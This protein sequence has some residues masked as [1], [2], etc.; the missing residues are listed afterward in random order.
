MPEESP[1]HRRGCSRNGRTMDGQILLRRCD[2][3]LSPDQPHADAS[4]L[5]SLESGRNADIENAQVQHHS[6]PP[7]SAVV[8][9][10]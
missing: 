7:R 8:T 6:S 3:Q 10:P 1:I 9:G 2:L 4:I 5:P